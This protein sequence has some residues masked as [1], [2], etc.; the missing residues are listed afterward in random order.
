MT[1]KSLERLR[2]IPWSELRGNDQGLEAALDEVLGGAA[3]DRVLDRLLRK[4]RSA[5]P[6]LRSALAEAVFGV[7]LW[8]RRL[9]A[10]LP[11]ASALKLLAAGKAAPSR[12]R[13]K[14]TP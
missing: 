9:G 6:G 1:M 10:A 13:H 2:S 7:G 8:R 3:A 5:S 12:R 11:G 14:P 4:H